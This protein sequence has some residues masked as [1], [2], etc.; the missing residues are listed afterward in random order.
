MTRLN[1][2]KKI[3]YF[4]SFVVIL[5]ANINNV[6]SQ[7]VIINNI[8]YALNIDQATVVSSTLKDNTEISIPSKINYGGKDY[9]VTTIGDYAF[10]RFNKL[11]NVS[12][13]DSIFSIGEYAFSSCNSLEEISIPPTLNIIGQRAFSYCS[14]LKKIELPNE[15]DEINNRAF[16]ECVLLERIRMPQTLKSLGEGAFSGCSTLR[17]ITLPQN[18]QVLQECTFQRCT[19]LQSVQIPQTL[20]QLK[21]QAFINCENLEH[22]HI[23]TSIEVLEYAFANCNKIT[24]VV[25][26]SS[27]LD[28]NY[29]YNY[30]F[31]NHV[32][33][34]TLNIESIK[35]PI[36][37][38]GKSITVGRNCKSIEADVLKGTTI[39]T[40]Y[41]S[42][43]IRS[44]GNQND[45]AV[46]Y[47]TYEGSIEEWNNIYNF[48]DMYPNEFFYGRIKPNECFEREG[49]YF[50]ALDT[51][52]S[53]VSVVRGKN[54]YTGNLYIPKE[55]N[56]GEQKFR[57]V[58][59]ANNTFENCID[60]DSIFFEGNKVEWQKII[61][62]KN[63]DILRNVPI[64]YNYKHK[65]TENTSK[66]NFLYIDNCKFKKGEKQELA[67]KL[68]NTK[69][70][71]SF[72]FE[73]NLPE[74]FSLSINENKVYKA[75]I[76]SQR[77]STLKHDIF[78]ISKL[79]S[80]N[81][82]VICGST[83]NETFVGNDGTAISL[84]IDVD[85]NVTDGDYS[86]VLK[87]ITL[88][89]DNG[90]VFRTNEINA[91]VVV[92]SDIRGD[93]NNDQEVNIGDISCIANIVLG[94]IADSY[95]LK[96]ADV[97]LDGDI[98]VGDVAYT[99]EYIINGSFP[100]T[101][102][103][104]NLYMLPN[105]MPMLSVPDFEMQTGNDY[106]TTIS[107]TSNG[108][109][110]AF[111][112]D[113]EL[114]KGLRIKREFGKECIVQGKHISD[115]HILEWAQQENTDMRF[116]GYSLSNIAFNKG[117]ENLISIELVADND[118]MSGV[119]PIVLKNI[120]LATK[121]QTVK[122][123][124]QIV[125]VSVNQ[126][127][128]I[129]NIIDKSTTEDV[130]NIQGIKLQNRQRGINIINR[131]KVLIK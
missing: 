98:N 83:T 26:E 17:N 6:Y 63:N 3:R 87:N 91:T 5:Y 34:Y 90:D 89:C 36:G 44:I 124:D 23:P 119:Y 84:Y 18:L 20:K 19:A 118:I 56:F 29:A 38:N 81:Y 131:K 66:D 64:V 99:A 57:I 42:R 126:T 76:A 68:R 8:K 43:N 33:H 108:D 123:Y 69:P 97:N 40:L 102:Y 103:K 101:T 50:C 110:T 96:A 117:I 1:I 11:K 80:G 122:L 94:D 21:Y 72:Q 47:V 25:I 13:P 39:D 74:G 120:V 49:V 62:G 107:L 52:L 28:A 4:L 71:T 2:T 14:N 61:I 46:K 92:R 114:P 58:K 111:Q 41:L 35:N 12:L 31:G 85:E 65:V 55:V 7:D 106:G 37:L 113:M 16:E 10:Y 45:F 15:M 105:N 112:F 59:I 24:S 30:W 54:A 73:L 86:F 78:E 104:K 27:K 32:Q 53:T 121:T 60:L 93:V 95:N 125:Y 79:K 88:A 77:S 130:F 115:S 9:I 109:I 75:E 82:L 116:M 67:I 22:I 51:F 129:N 128:S 48:S 127:T 100:N 70:I